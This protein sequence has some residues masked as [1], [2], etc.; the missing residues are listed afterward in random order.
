MQ[1]GEKITVELSLIEP[2]VTLASFQS[3]ASL[4]AFDAGQHALFYQC[5]S[6][7]TRV[8]GIS[9]QDGRLIVHARGARH[10]VQAVSIPQPNGKREVLGLGWYGVDESAAESPVFSLEGRFSGL[11]VPTPDGNCVMSNYPAA[12]PGWTREACCICALSMAAN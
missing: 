12:M 9:F 2:K 11:E 8:S 4:A 5:P 1:S 3:A 10:A 7:R 6:V